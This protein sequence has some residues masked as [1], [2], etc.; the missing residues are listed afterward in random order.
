MEPV[1]IVAHDGTFHTDDVFA[2]AALSLAFKDKEVEITR[3]RLDAIINSADIVVDVGGVYDPAAGR[4]DHHQK[5]GAG[6]RDNGIPYASFGL[7]WKEYG[8]LLAGSEDSAR[9][10]DEQLVQGIDGADNGV[11]NKVADN[12][13]YCY[14]V[15]DIISAM[16]TTWEEEMT[17]DE[18]F[19]E[20]VNMATTIL[21]RMIA[22]AQSY[23][24][25]QDIL[26]TAYTQS[27][28][29][30]IID[31]Q[32]E[33]PGW[34]EVMANHPEPLFVVYERE[35]GKWSAKGVRA[36][37]MEF[38]LRKQFPE[39]WAGLRDAEL[40]AASGVVDAI[41]CHNGRFIAVAE[42]R[43]GAIELAQKA[44]LL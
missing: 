24:H 40:Q 5:D 4:F 1:T 11:L 35:D 23:A 17:M 28:N 12:G 10:I 19:M 6:A 31:I 42:S 32:S 2:C 22:H 25:A 26:E 29:K 36:N 27:E 34:Y 20:A 37:P 44:I 21:E 18:A 30:Q 14:S 38:A 39:A 9:F 3:S 15:I 16:R 7:V 33:Y 8:R 13:V 43:A 41:F